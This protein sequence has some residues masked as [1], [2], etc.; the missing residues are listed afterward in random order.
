MNAHESHNK[1]MRQWFEERTGL[2]NAL[3]SK[4]M[5]I[6]DKMLAIQQEPQVSFAEPN[7]LEAG[8]SD[9]KKELPNNDRFVIIYWN[10]GYHN[11]M[12]V[13]SYDALDMHWYDHNRESFTDDVKYWREF[14]LKP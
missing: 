11:E 1:R 9:V 6:I 7:Q 14:P 8:W 3:L 5:R 4:H 12:N 2:K 13:A 10:N